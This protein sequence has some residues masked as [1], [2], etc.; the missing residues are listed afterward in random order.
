MWCT[1]ALG[2]ARRKTCTTTRAPGRRSRSFWIC[3][4][5]G[6]DWRAGRDTE[7]SWITRVSWKHA[8]HPSLISCMAL[9]R[10]AVIRRASVFQWKPEIAVIW[11]RVIWVM[12]AKWHRHCWLSPSCFLH[13]DGFQSGCDGLCSGSNSEMIVW[14]DL[15]VWFAADSTGTHSLYTRYQD[16]EI[17][18]HV[19][20]MLP[21]TANNTQQ[22]K[23]DER[24]RFP[25]L[26]VA[27]SL[28]KWCQT[29]GFH[30]I[31]LIRLN[32]SVTNFL[33][34]LLCFAKLKKKKKNLLYPEIGMTSRVAVFTPTFG[35]FTVASEADFFLFIWL[36][37][38]WFQPVCCLWGNRK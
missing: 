23:C 36:C 15:C 20:T 21:Y 27:K 32:W 18:F 35:V 13:W 7:L 34:R 6:C 25:A 33:F 1:A 17:M 11:P 22:V 37:S 9:C 26:P 29:H 8:P 4:E 16:Y 28:L 2:R 5:S 3:S 38:L 12:P 10:S 24:L 19:S 14:F 30:R 31:S